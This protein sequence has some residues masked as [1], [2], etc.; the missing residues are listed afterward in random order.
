M[1]K[2][3]EDKLNELTLREEDAK[4]QVSNWEQMYREWM[5]TMESRVSNLQ[6]TNQDLQV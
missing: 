6:M 3:Y 1:K 4:K 5:A 2:E